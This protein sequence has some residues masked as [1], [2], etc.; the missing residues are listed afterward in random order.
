[1]SK[2]RNYQNGKV[3]RVVD[4]SFQMC[5]IGST[6][7]KLSSRMSSHKAKY[8]KFKN[9]NEGSYTTVY[10]IFDDYGAENCKIELIE[11]FP[12]SCKEELTAREGHHQRNEECV[13]KYIAGRTKKEWAND[14]S[15]EIAR[16]QKAWADEHK[17]ERKTYKATYYSTNKEKLLEQ[18][19]QYRENNKDQKHKRDKEYRENNKDIIRDKEKQPFHCLCGCVVQLTEKAR[20]QKTA[21][22]HRLLNQNSAK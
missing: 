12:C 19:K 10:K 7:E 15:E 4:N 3:Y 8:K 20:H 14:N 13:N 2:E 22:H 5:Y 21:K 11:L 1:M 9:L 16:R 17:D 18:A 6:I